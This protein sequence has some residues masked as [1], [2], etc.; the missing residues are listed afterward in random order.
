MINKEYLD[1]LVSNAQ[2]NI[3]F[4]STAITMYVREDELAGILEGKLNPAAKSQ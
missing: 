4:I 1:D 3:G 2:E